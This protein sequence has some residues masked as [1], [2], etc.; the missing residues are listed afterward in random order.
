[1]IAGIVSYSERLEYRVDLQGG[2]TLT[3]KSDKGNAT[4][5][6]QIQGA[7]EVELIGPR[8]GLIGYVTLEQEGERLK[9]KRLSGQERLLT[10]VQ[11]AL[12]LAP[13][14]SVM[15]VEFKALEKF[16]A[17]TPTRQRKRGKE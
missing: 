5:F 11:E 10:A 12:T 8:F 15:S 4:I 14:G 16:L 9:T 13:E 1:M 2:K 6:T 7:Q 17:E 3:Y